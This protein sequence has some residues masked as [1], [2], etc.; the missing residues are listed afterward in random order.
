M[1]IGLR[2][3]LNRRSSA[4]IQQAEWPIFL[5]DAGGVEDQLHVLT[6]LHEQSQQTVD[7]EGKDRVKDAYPADAW[8]R[9]VSLKNKYDPGNLF[10]MN[11]NIAPSG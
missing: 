11:Q 7:F 2:P 6:L 3:I 4:Q 10:R 8:K 5:L 9:L 1:G